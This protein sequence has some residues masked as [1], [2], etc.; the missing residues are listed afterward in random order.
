[1][2]LGQVTGN[3][4]KES[5]SVGIAKR[6][7]ERNRKIKTYFNEND[8]R[9]NLDGQLTI[10]RRGYER[11]TVDVQIKTLPENYSDVNGYYYDCDTKVFNVVKAKVTQ[12]PV[13][14]LLVDIINEKVYTILCT[15][16]YVQ[17]LRV[18]EQ[19]VKRI[20]F[21][22]EELFDELEFINKIYEVVKIIENDKQVEVKCGVIRSVLKKRNKPLEE[23]YQL[24]YVQNSIKGYLTSYSHVTPGKKYNIILIKIDDENKYE[25]IQ[26][27]IDKNIININRSIQRTRAKDSD[28]I[29]ILYEFVFIYD[30]PLLYKSAGVP[31]FYIDNTGGL[32]QNN[33]WLLKAE[34]IDKEW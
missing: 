8:K 9:T 20:R 24:I 15:T 5:D 34:L 14:L 30:R 12:N 28:I 1:M 10:I 31:L 26:V 16:D 32:M 2:N 21:S 13:I 7:L 18:K 3:C 29:N 33:I 6:I 17:K 23:D 25:K 11:I 27:L 22:D 19:F 4:F